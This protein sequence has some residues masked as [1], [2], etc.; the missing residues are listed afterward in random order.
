MSL[1]TFTHL[2]SEQLSWHDGPDPSDPD[3]LTPA[4]Q[5]YVACDPL[6]FLHASCEHQFCGYVRDW[7]QLVY[8]H[9]IYS[10]SD[11]AASNYGYSEVEDTSNDSESAIAEYGDSDVEDTDSDAGLYS[12]PASAAGMASDRAAWRVSPCVEHTTE[13]EQGPRNFSKHSWPC[14]MKGSEP[15]P[16]TN[17]NGLTWAV[18][19]PIG[20]Q[21]GTLV[22]KGTIT[23]AYG[24]PDREKF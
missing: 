9:H 14:L 21:F 1:P 22:E 5:Y 24:F 11:S 23:S 7:I 8:S 16:K 6:L 2:T 19:T 15:L 18:F 4:Y 20:I 13:T 17:E 12:M 10:D 3:G